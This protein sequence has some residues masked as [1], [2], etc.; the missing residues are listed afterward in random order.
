MIE[1]TLLASYSGPASLSVFVGESIQLECHVSS[2]TFQ[3]THLSVFVLSDP[4]HLLLQPST[5]LFYVL[6]IFPQK[7]LSVLLSKPSPFPL[8]IFVVLSFPCRPLLNFFGTV[9]ST[10]HIH[11]VS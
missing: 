9:V 2:Q 1:D 5:I 3:H 6:G 7:F 4:Y 11:F 10:C 8:C